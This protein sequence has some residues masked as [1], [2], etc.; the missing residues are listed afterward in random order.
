[1]K[2]PKEE[3]RFRLRRKEPKQQDFDERQPADDGN[4]NRQSATRPYIVC[5]NH[6]KPDRQ[7]DDTEN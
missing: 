1:M 3:S 7:S 6:R 4:D 5:E 2:L